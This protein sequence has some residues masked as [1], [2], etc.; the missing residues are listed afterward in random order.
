VI[1][2]SLLRN[3]QPY[4]EQYRNLVSL[5]KTASG[6]ALQVVNGELNPT[7]IAMFIAN[8]M[9][10][11]IFIVDYIQLVDEEGRIVKR[12]DMPTNVDSK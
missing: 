7:D 6:T 8:A 4:N 2:C 1:F 5:S 11:W 9:K 3:I 12:H 10:H